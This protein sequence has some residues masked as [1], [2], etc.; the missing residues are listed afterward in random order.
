MLSL[1]GLGLHDEKDTTLRGLEEAKECDAL[2]L[3]RYT[4]QWKGLEGLQDLVDVRIEEVQRSKLEENLDDILQEAED[5]RVGILI[6]GDPLVATTHREILIQA[7][8]REIKTK[9]IHSS[10]IYSAVAETGLQIYKFGK[11][12]TV[13]FEEEGYRPESPYETIKENRE[14]GLHTL[15][16]LDIK[17]GGA[18][19][20]CDA[21]SY[22]LQLEKEKEEGIINPNDR[23]VALSIKG[24]E[25]YISYD[26]VDAML[27]RNFE[28]PSVLVFPGD[29]HV[30]EEEAL[31]IFSED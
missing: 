1:I 12:T 4:S 24:E 27:Q 15:V 19:E 26:T 23:V 18:L 3:E 20:V 11:T 28:T 6:P 25:R 30:K 9:V 7:K 8:K 5:E 22:L 17:D 21:L 13:P 29:L 31:E 2:Y 14:R 16:L 10:S